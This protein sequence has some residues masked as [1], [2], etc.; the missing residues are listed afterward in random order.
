M[1]YSV[2]SVS[3]PRR[4]GSDRRGTR[5]ADVRLGLPALVTVVLATPNCVV[6]DTDREADAVEG[7][8]L[9]DVRVEVAEVIKT[10]AE[11]DVADEAVRTVLGGVVLVVLDGVVS[12]AEVEGGVVLSAVALDVLIVPRVVEIG[13]AIA[14][15][16]ELVGI[17]IFCVVLGGVL[18]FGM[19]L[20]ISVE[21]LMGLFWALPAEAAVVVVVAVLRNVMEVAV[22]VMAKAPKEELVP[23]TLEHEDDLH[24]RGP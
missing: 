1:P 6:G 21:G 14:A 10:V 22:L 8:M 24:V 19:V 5:S 7:A 12:G 17:V 2:S 16:N 13:V 18:E 23:L 20:V 4:I 15:M 11:E 9:A 3:V